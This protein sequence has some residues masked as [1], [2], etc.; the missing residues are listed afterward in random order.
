MGDLIVSPSTQPF[1]TPFCEIDHSPDLG[2]LSNQ[3]VRPFH[4]NEGKAVL[5][6]MKSI[7]PVAE[8]TVEQMAQ[9]ARVR[10]MIRYFGSLVEGIGPGGL[11][12]CDVRPGSGFQS[13]FP[14]HFRKV[15]KPESWIWKIPDCCISI[16]AP[17][18]RTFGDGGHR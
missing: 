8:Q 10:A 1:S 11:R 17:T 3:G 4:L 5:V 2:S 12:A 13:S 15:R 14:F 6:C 18:V 9:V 7:T 16:S